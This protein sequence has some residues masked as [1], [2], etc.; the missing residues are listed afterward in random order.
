MTEYIVNYVY[1][2]MY[3]LYVYCNY[4]YDVLCRGV[5]G[6]FPI[7]DFST[8]LLGDLRPHTSCLLTGTRTNLT[9]DQQGS[10]LEAGAKHRKGSPFAAPL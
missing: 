6:L 7:S 9:V 5:A 8:L 3:G 4:C 2:F 10:S 1:Y